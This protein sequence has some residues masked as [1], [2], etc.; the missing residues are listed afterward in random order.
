MKKT[1]EYMIINHRDGDQ[2]ARLNVLGSFGWELVSVVA[3]R[4]YMK[5]EI[6]NDVNTES[7]LKLTAYTDHIG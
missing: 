7:D 6:T 4:L 1:F 3:K 2:I 5:R